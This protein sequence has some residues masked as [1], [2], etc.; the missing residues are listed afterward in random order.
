M[1][2]EIITAS[3]GV[4]VE[5]LVRTIN[6]FAGRCR[7][8]IAHKRLEQI[9]VSSCSRV[10]EISIIFEV[11]RTCVDAVAI[12]TCGVWK[13]TININGTQLTEFKLRGFAKKVFG[14]FT[15][16]T[17]RYLS[18]RLL[19]R[20]TTQSERAVNIGI[21]TRNRLL[22]SIIVKQLIRVIFSKCKKQSLR[23]F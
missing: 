21:K 12:H 16:K 18:E 20:F 22:Y 5:K 19:E 3:G 15:M 8:C 2:A 7:G 11:C 4:V 9:C 1:R 13:L 10:D 14:S 23:I 17:Q 6:P